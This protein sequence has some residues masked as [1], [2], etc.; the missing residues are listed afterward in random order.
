[1]ELKFGRK[2]QGLESERTGWLG[3]KGFWELLGLE[4]GQVSG[5]QRARELSEEKRPGRVRIGKNGAERERR[6]VKLI[7]PCFLFIL[8]S[9]DAIPSS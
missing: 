8:P 2:R 3:W 7:V 5:S 4:L 6:R 9:N 1:M